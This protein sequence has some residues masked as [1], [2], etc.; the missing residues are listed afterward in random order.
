MTADTILVTPRSITRGGHP[1]LTR[2]EQAGYA[3]RMCRPGEQPN[4]DELLNLLPGCVGY[5]AGVELITRR[6]LQ[7]ATRLR[8]I[9]RNGTGVNNID[10]AAASELKI[11][12][13]RAD[14]A[15]ARGVAEL[16]IG[17]M[18]ALL[19]NI[20]AADRS[21]KVGTWQRRQGTEI[22][23]RILGIIGCGKIGQLVAD[24]AGKLGMQV[25]AYDPIPHT[26]QAAAIGYRY[27]SLDQLLEQADIV[28]LHCPPATD[29]APVITRR[30]IEKMK[31]GAH[32]INTVRG[33]LLE[34][35]ALVEFLDNGK[36]AGVAVDAYRTEPPGRHPLVVHERV[37]AVPHIGAYTTESIQQ[38]VE[39]AVD[40]LLEALKDRRG[41]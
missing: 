12:V 20:P 39:M 15:N 13:L 31:P 38:A 17:L 18:L 6:S 35:D 41:L 3:I 14:G 11:A 33:E 10:L 24:L 1:T 7:Q 34:D 8:V 30:E 28:S 27:V 26:Q 9:S 32:L 25:M 22:R 2:L 40:N 4:E 5:L 36:L 16:T 37:I 19:R 23:G 29:G 21:L